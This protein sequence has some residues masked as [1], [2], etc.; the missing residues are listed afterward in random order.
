MIPRGPCR[1]ERA[2]AEG[3]GGDRGGARSVREWLPRSVV[4]LVHV[5]FVVGLVIGGRGDLVERAEGR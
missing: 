1:S 3:G 4:G 5:G 2:D